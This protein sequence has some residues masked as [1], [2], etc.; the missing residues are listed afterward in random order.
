MNLQKM[1]AF[2]TT[3]ILRFNSFSS[4]DDASLAA[5]CLANCSCVHRF[6][7]DFNVASQGGCVTE[8]KI[9]CTSR[10]PNDSMFQ[11]EFDSFL[12]QHR[13]LMV[14]R[15]TK[16]PLTD[17][18]TGICRL[19]KLREI[20]VTHRRNSTSVPRDC[21]REMTNANVVDISHNQIERIPEGLFSGLQN[22]KKIKLGDNPIKFFGIEDF[23]NASELTSLQE[24]HVSHYPLSTFEPWPF[25]RANVIAPLEFKFYIQNNS[26]VHFTNT[27]GLNLNNCS[28][29]DGINLY[30]V[31][32]FGPR[33]RI[34]DLLN[35]WGFSTVNDFACTVFPIESPA[36]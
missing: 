30:F 29:V 22:L 11:Q 31:L 1:A 15:V 17:L 14:L 25:D 35:G 21:F 13:N 33:R 24:I 5:G 26:I 20:Y 23:A 10:S 9:D 27:I 36:V 19:T 8:L 3:V 12:L 7:A 18:K 32:K 28:M 6:E 2:L 4:I 16:M 34:M